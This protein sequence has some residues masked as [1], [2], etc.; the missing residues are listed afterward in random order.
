[1]Q[2]AEPMR[3]L[4]VLAHPLAESFTAAQC[5]AAIAQAKAN[6]HEIRQINLYAESFQPCL[7][8]DELRAYPDP[9]SISATL[10]N[11]VEAL[12]WAEGLILCFP[13]WWSGQ[14]A[15]LK[16]WFDRVWR[17]GIAFHTTLSPS[18]LRP[19]LP[20]IRLLGVLTTLGAAR[21]Q[22]SLLLGAPGRKQL[23]RGLRPCLAP[24]CKT[25]WLAHYAIDTSTA[26]SRAAHLQKI[27]R[28][29]A[30]IAV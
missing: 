3:L 15:I 5:N 12:H 22:W 1:M 8:A 23:L 4:F 25:F 18:A 20:Q 10:D 16:G 21:W 17:P 24:R 29:I 6:G 14:P 26:A 30:Q 19:G 9:E 11:H 13:T 28:Q 2:W 27:A 7:S